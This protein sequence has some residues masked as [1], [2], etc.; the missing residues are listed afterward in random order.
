MALGPKRLKLV[1]EINLVLEEI[2][3]RMTVR[4]IYYQ[5]VSRHIIENSQNSYKSF[6]ATL[7]LA[8]KDGL[9]PLDAILDTSKPVLKKPSWSGLDGFFESVEASY[10]RSIWLTQGNYVEVWLEKDA[11][12]GIFEPI[13]DKYDCYLVIG[14]GYQSYTNLVEASKRFAPNKPNYI[15]YFGDFDPTG[16][17][18]PRSIEKGLLDLGVESLRLTC[19]ALTPEQIKK[20]DIPLNLTKESDTRTK[21][22]VQEHGDITAELDALHPKVLTRLIETSI[23]KNLF[24][25]FWK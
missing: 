10:A 23:G 12:R 25:I 7:T 22:F 13:T 8:R 24:S 19:V 6:D 3:M 18:I 9:V 2:N 17:D 15:L 21:A 1:D 5:L 11:L 16:L 20:Y 4:Q 14:K